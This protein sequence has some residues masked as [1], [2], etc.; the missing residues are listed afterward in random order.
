VGATTFALSYFKPNKRE[1][2]QFICV[3]RYS[4]VCWHR[5]KVYVGHT[6]SLRRRFHQEYRGV[7]GS[8]LKPFFD[9]ALRN[10]C[11]I[12]IRCRPTVSA[13]LTL[14]SKDMMAQEYLLNYSGGFSV[15]ET[16]WQTRLNY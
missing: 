4:A 6:S 8:H 7:Q 13:F 1:L 3:E 11:E 5:Y 15:D 14:W 9:E 12:C 10:G 2:F 16:L